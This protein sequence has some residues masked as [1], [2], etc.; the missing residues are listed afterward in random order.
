MK[1]R[2]WTAVACAALLATGFAGS[3]FAGGSPDSSFGTSG[4]AT[5]PASLSVARAV[6]VQ[7]DGKIVVAGAVGASLLV[8]RYDASGTLDT[9]FGSGGTATVTVQDSAEATSLLIEPDGKLVVG[10]QTTDSTADTAA[11]LVA[12]LNVDGSLDSSFGSGG[13][14][15][16]Q[17]GTRGTVRGLALQSDGKIVAV[18]DTF[19]Q[20]AGGHEV[21]IARLDADG[22]LDSSFGSGGVLE[23]GGGIGEFAYAVSVESNGDIAVAGQHNSN[24]GTVWLLDSS[25][26]SLATTTI[27]STY[28]ACGL[29]LLSSGDLL[30]GGA[31]GGGNLTLT[32]LA[33]DGS[34]DTS[35]GSSG[36]S[37]TS[38]GLQADGDGYFC[39]LLPQTDGS[40]YAAVTT[41]G[42]SGSAFT[43]AH[44]DAAGAPDTSFGAN[45]GEQEPVSG[46]AYGIAQQSDGMILLAGQESVSGANHAAVER[47]DLSGG[48]TT[49]SSAPPGAAG[50]LV[51]LGAPSDCIA[52][53][54]GTG[55]GATGAGLDG[56]DWLAI[57]P[58]GKN[59]YVASF[60]SN[61]VAE[62]ARN[63]DGSLTQL[64]GANACV[65]NTGSTE[66]GTT[67]AGL[68]GPTSITVS[69][70]G[71]NVYVTA[72]SDDTVVVFQRG[73]D[74]SLSPLQCLQD[75]AATYD[76]CATKVVGLRN[77]YDIAVS[78]DGDNAYVAAGG[79]GNVRG[80]VA[81]FARASDGTL[82]QLASPNDCLEEA[83]DATPVCGTSDGKGLT[84]ATA[85]AL[86][87]SGANLY[88]VSDD[89]PGAVAEFTR[90]AGG[91]LTQPSGASAC[92]G[93]TGGTECSAS[94]GGLADLVDVAVS[95][96]GSSLYT[97]SD[98]AA[99]IVGVFSIG[100]GGA[101]TPV[102]CVSSLAEPCSQR[103]VGTNSAFGLALSPDGAN[104]YVAAAGSSTLGAA[105][106]VASFAR[107][108]DGD[109]TQLPSPDDCTQA[110]GASVCGRTGTGLSDALSVVVSPDGDNAYVASS[111]AGAGGAVAEFARVGG[112]SGGGGSTT[113]TTTTPAASP[114]TSGSG[115]PTGTLTV[116]LAGTG[117]V[118]SQ[119]AG[120]ACPGTCTAS[121]PAGTEVT[122]SATAGSNWSFASWNNCSSVSGPSCTVTVGPGDQRVTALYSELTAP[123]L[124]YSLVPGPADPGTASSRTVTLSFWAS[125]PADRWTIAWGDGQ[126]D[127]CYWCALSPTTES[128]PVAISHTYA[129]GAPSS[130]TISVQAWF[131]SSALS[132]SVEVPLSVPVPERSR[133]TLVAGGNGE[134][135]VV[136]DDPQL[137][138]T[139]TCTV[140]VPTGKELSLDAVPADGQPLSGWGGA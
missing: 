41:A 18:G 101:L 70:D 79:W 89:S 86:T 106:A 7:P 19:D 117:T 35:Y 54:A 9:S 132:S 36:T 81:E 72:S 114:T 92:V 84:A 103:A 27:A 51:Q 90:G 25:G 1:K 52:E 38:I 88:A 62:F 69:P 16:I 139:A 8:A 119:P 111:S 120:I 42:G 128:H 30:V 3:T 63:S 10:G 108:S 24:T 66:C 80:D 121:F 109:L 21:G 77:A 57:S 40:A 49:T 98:V 4:V 96:D 125:D 110:S 53:S 124:Q 85:L 61:A 55:C 138:C 126:T 29:A 12:R 32:R 23:R 140:S 123:P 14:T 116:G 73:S 11:F 134:G 68:R 26:T 115:S 129:V 97:A 13:E 20:G 17:I 118:V 56:A 44:L 37:T 39:P 2:I 75:A 95:P 131:A 67:A 99:G 105:P 91:A 60:S 78:A 102:T 104:L 33:A 50:A 112:S 6:A 65:G 82:T 46:R 22:T 137:R 5:Y 76:R 15:T 83:G 113:I 47:V 59:V 93:S 122:L 87:P 28:Q 94:A 71:R 100:S 74:G 34:I 48:G 43:L 133:L 31:T 127:E 45:G 58:D 135:A 107:N 130:A 64:A 136:L